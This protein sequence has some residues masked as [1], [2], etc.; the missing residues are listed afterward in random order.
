IN[1]TIPP[2]SHHDLRG[3]RLR[4]HGPQRPPAGLHG[5]CLSAQA[6]YSSRT[7]D[8]PNLAR[9]L[10]PSSPTDSSQSSIIENATSHTLRR[11]LLALMKKQPFDEQN[12][13]PLSAINF[14]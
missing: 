5:S 3:Q 11:E 2:N 10:P 7:L 6:A 4:T 9:L 12:T 8:G 1:E 14:H 13:L